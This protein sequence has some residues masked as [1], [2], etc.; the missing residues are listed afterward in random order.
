MRT[1]DN[2]ARLR[3]KNEKCKIHIGFSEGEIMEDNFNIQE[4]LE[5]G[6]E[7]ILRSAVKTSLKSP[8]ESLFLLKF[9]KYAKNATKMRKQYHQK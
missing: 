9:S 1:T 4:Y 2:A 8:K 7:N 3:I 6:V 5:N